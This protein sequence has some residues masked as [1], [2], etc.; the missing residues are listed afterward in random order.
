MQ[1]VHL[2]F[3]LALVFLNSFSGFSYSEQNSASISAGLSIDAV[4]GAKTIVGI[5]DAFTALERK[6]AEKF[7]VDLHSGLKMSLRGLSMVAVE[8]PIDY[9]GMIV[10]HEFFGHGARCQEYGGKIAFL[11]LAPVWPYGSGVAEMGCLNV[12]LTAMEHHIQNVGG[13]SSGD[14]MAQHLAMKSIANGAISG[15][16]TWLYGL[17]ALQTTG[18]LWAGKLLLESAGREGISD[19]MNNYVVSI[20]RLYRDQNAI[21]HQAL[22]NWSL[23]NFL[24]PLILNNFYAM[25]HYVRYGEDARTWMIP[26]GEDVRY[27]PAIKLTL[28]PFGPEFTMHNYLLLFER[29]IN[30]TLRGGYTSSTP[31]FGVGISGQAL[32]YQT[33]TL[34]GH[35]E[36]WRQPEILLPANFY[37]RDDSDRGREFLNADYGFGSQTWGVLGSVVA[38]WRFI[39]PVALDLELGGKT[40]GYVPGEAINAHFLVRGGLTL[41]F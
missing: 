20:N 29:A 10:Q 28:A 23:I 9:L 39:D 15:P 35:L 3:L 37:Y 32:R 12:N 4:S 22:R 26:F 38:S 16:S 41:F 6:S 2:Y 30:V 14:V 19:D 17:S 31:Y 36:M 40:K 34:G 33:L 21:S 13:V 18:Y 5:R 11:Y 25:Y 1:L 8:L 24:D 7:S 27:L